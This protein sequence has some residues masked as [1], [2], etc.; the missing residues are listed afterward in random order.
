MSEEAISVGD[1][2]YCFAIPAYSGDVKLETMTSLLETT[3]KL[4][5]QNV[6]WS[7][8]TIKGNALIDS[9]RNELTHRFLHETD[10]DFM[11]C[12]D[13]DVSWKWQDMLRLLA[14]GNKY[15]FACGVYCARVDP[16]KFT[17]NSPHLEQNEYGLVP[18]EGVGFGFVIISRELLLKL[19]VATYTKKGWGAP[20]KQ[21][22]STGVKDGSYYGEDML[23]C[24]M[25][26][27]QTGCCIMAD[28]VIE[29]KHHGN[30]D[31]A[32]LFKDFLP[33]MLENQNGISNP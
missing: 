3:G 30:K 29:L 4:S 22:F 27:E 21:F 7:F 12:I 6:A 33:I 14:W 23:F 1:K 32:Y 17:I 11:V 28:P 16:P 25:V 20:I 19:D 26:K 10:A 15:Q 5:E 31:Y 24:K 9:A 2:K 8:L 18:L 13:A